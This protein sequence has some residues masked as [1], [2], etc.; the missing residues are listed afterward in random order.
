QRERHGALV[1]RWEREEV[2]RQLHVA[3]GA[4]EAEGIAD[5]TRDVANIEGR[6]VLGGAA[7]IVGIAVALPPVDRVVA[8]AA[9]VADMEREG[10]AVGAGADLAVAAGGADR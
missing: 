2:I 3:V 9:V 1:G 8:E 7:R 10:A 5:L 4:V 6:A